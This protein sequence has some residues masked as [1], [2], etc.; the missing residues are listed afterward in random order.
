MH[1][2]R[3]SVISE[4]NNILDASV[5][6]RHAFTTAFN[7]KEKSQVIS[8]TF[9]EIDNFRFVV[10]EMNDKTWHVFECPGKTFITGEET[11]CNVFNDCIKRIRPW[12]TRLLEECVV[13]IEEPAEI[14]AH[15]RVNLEHQANELPKPDEPFG[16]EEALQWQ[17]KLDSL[18]E[19]LEKLKEANEIQDFEIGTLRKDL[20]SLKNQVYNM[21][22]KLWF[23]SAGNKILNA[24]E[25]V[26]NSK[27]LEKLLQSATLALLIENASHGGSQ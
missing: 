16:T 8:I 5:F 15:M 13:N 7:N 14:L 10:E 4:I 24:L 26:S 12:L 2:I 19:E 18:V 9:K 17:Q 27:L 11:A 6:T 21:P 20:E 25:R 3:D 1:L 22:K 23:L